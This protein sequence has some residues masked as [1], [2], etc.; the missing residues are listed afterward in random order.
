MA[1]ADDI[2]AGLKSTGAIQTVTFKRRNGSLSF[3]AQAIIVENFDPGRLSA[4]GLTA[5]QRTVQGEVSK[6]TLLRSELEAEGI[7]VANKPDIHDKLKD[8]NDVTFGILSSRLSRVGSW[9]ILAIAN[10][11]TSKRATR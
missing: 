5:A 3:E 6:F 1:Q 7:T 10:N 11:R 8:E 2:F 9:E 4:K